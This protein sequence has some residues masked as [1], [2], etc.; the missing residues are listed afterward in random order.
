MSAPT[1]ETTEVTVVALVHDVP[2]L[3]D[4][5]SPSRVLIPERVILSLTREVRPESAAEWASVSVL[6]PRRLKSGKP[7]REISSFGWEGRTQYGNLTVSRPD[8]LTSVIADR[9][10]MGWSTDL[11]D[12]SGDWVS[13]GAS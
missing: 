11:V 13:D 2:D 9:L 6:G 3:A 10:P 1:S 5:T 7:G 4:P 8:W 12:L